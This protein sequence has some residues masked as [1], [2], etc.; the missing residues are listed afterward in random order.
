MSRKVEYLMLALISDPY[1]LPDGIK[2]YYTDPKA[3]TISTDKI[4]K[5][6]AAI[7]ALNVEHKAN[8]SVDLWN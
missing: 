5:V 1:L 3:E 6:K 7:N 4:E 8:Y 2:G